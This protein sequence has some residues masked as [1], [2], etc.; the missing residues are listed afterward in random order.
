MKVSLTISVLAAALA[1]AP[2]ATAAAAPIVRLFSPPSVFQ[3][4]HGGDR[5][6]GRRHRHDFIGPVAPVI[7]EAVEPGP[8]AASSPVLVSAPVFVSVTFAP[9]A[10][11]AAMDPIPGPKIIEIGRSAPQRRHLPLVIYGD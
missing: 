3:P 4:W 7:G 5:D 6:F 1:A 10:G 9:G 11:P 2:G 8:A